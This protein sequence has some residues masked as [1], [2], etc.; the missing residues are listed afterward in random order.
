[1]SPQPHRNPP[2]GQVTRRP[3]GIWLR[4]AHG[5]TGRR[6]RFP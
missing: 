1:M 6:R 3:V 2:Y 5:V 4:S